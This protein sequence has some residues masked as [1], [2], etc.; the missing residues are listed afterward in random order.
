MS[1]S[2]PKPIGRPP[3]SVRRISRTASNDVRP[4]DEADVGQ[5]VGG[6]G[7]AETR[8]SS[9][10]EPGLGVDWQVTEQEYALAKELDLLVPRQ[11]QFR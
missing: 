8:R 4:G 6:R 3:S 1:P 11:H 2:W 9:D 10:G 7:G 5:P